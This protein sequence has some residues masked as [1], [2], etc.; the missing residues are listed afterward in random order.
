MYVN[1]KPFMYPT[2]ISMLERTAYNN[3][4]TCYY[5]WDKS[6]EELIKIYQFCVGKTITSF[7]MIDLNVDPDDAF[8]KNFNTILDLNQFK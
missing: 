2:S 6:V 1:I 8:R 5:Y 3:N 4:S 7:L